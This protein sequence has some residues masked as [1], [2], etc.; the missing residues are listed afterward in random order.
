MNTAQLSIVSKLPQSLRGSASGLLEPGQG[1]KAGVSG[2]QASRRPATDLLALVYVSTANR[3]LQPAELRHLVQ[4][5][6]ERNALEGITGVLLYSYG[7]FMQYLEGPAD[8]VE[9]VFGIIRADPMHSDVCEL[10]RE[11]I[12]AREFDDWSMAFRDI[13][14]FGVSDPP[15]I[16]D[17]FSGESLAD[18]PRDTPAHLLLSRFWNKGGVRRAL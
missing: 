17:V 12:A 11:P 7:K 16:D 10:L 15:G 1:G 8:A 2:R 13:S 3:W 18:A 9:R 6:R 5:A 14:A 4:R